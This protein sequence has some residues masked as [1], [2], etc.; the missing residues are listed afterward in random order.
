M[1]PTQPNKTTGRIEYIDALRGFTM[2]LVVFG[3]VVTFCLCTANQGISLNDYFTQVRMPMFFFVSG[4]VLYK[5]SVVW[6]SKQIISFF[7]KKIP[8]QLLSPLLFFLA[9]IHFM[10]FP[11][12]DV[13]REHTKAGYWFTY[14]LLEYYLIYTAVRFCFRGKWG[15]VIA[16]LIG[17]LLYVIEWPPLYDAIPLTKDWKEVL[18]VP[19][20][21]YFLYFVLGTLVH[22]NYP[23]VQKLLDSKWLLTFCIL[24]YFLINVFR[25]MM[26][27]NAL[28]SVVLDRTLSLTGL[29]ILF[30]FFRSKQAVF[31]KERALGRT[32]QYVGRRT[33][34]I[35][36][37]HY[38]LLP[39]G[40]QFNKVFVDHPMPVIEATVS[41]IL[42]GIIIAFC[43]VISNI[44]RLSPL[45]AQW[46]F[47]AK[48]PPKAQEPSV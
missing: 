10:G 42:A 21:D 46:L 19:K 29:V 1:N 20:W 26:N 44:I 5:D 4:F 33:L 23:L 37:I 3:H 40:M 15:H 11:F 32:I 8:V 35:Y 48:L 17:L 25:D 16:V 36:L 30:A 38:F 43:L 45:L 28:S 13:V 34:D 12:G 14:V 41:F 2:L 9:Y 24:Y 22:K 39:Y 7:R 18:S 6:N 31:S 27:L 47:G